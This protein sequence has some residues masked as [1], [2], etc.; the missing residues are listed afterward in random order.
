MVCCCIAHAER[1][2]TCTETRFRLSPKWTIPFKSAGVSVQSNAGSLGVCISFS[3]A[4]YTMFGGG[5]RVLATHSI[6]QFSL[7]FPSCASPCATRFWTSS[8]INYSI[9]ILNKFIT[10]LI[11][12][13]CGVLIQMRTSMG[14]QGFAEE[15]KNLFKQCV[16]RWQN[17]GGNISLWGPGCSYVHTGAL[18][19]RNHVLLIGI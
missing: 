9:G 12:V 14:V 4:G 13:N 5:V 16:Y 7:H 17:E 6:H 18:S 19:F 15:L 2:G 3:N 11:G 1:D 8:N 10:L